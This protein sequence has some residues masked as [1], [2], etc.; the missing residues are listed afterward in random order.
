MARVILRTSLM[1]LNSPKIMDVKQSQLLVTTEVQEEA[2]W[3]K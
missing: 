2:D 1:G 3:P